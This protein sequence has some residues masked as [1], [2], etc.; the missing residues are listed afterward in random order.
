MHKE[1]TGTIS[2]VWHSCLT[3]INRKFIDRVQK[4]AVKIRKIIYNIQEWPKISKFVHI[5]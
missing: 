1:C 4:A 5:R 3:K 2:V